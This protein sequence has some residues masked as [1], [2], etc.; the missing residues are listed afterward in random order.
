MKGF[1]NGFAYMGFIPSLGKYQQF[2][3]ETEYRNYL[4]GRGEGKWIWQRKH[5]ILLWTH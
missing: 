4:Q 1:Y 3:S 2:E 5:L